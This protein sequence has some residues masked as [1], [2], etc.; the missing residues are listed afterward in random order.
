VSTTYVDGTTPLDAVHMNALQQK[1][2]KSQANG[3]AALD[4]TGKVPAAQLPGAG[5]L[6]SPV[7]NGQWVKGVGGAAVWAPIGATDLPVVPCARVFHNAAQATVSG[8]DTPLA[9]NSELFDT[10]TIHDPAT[11]NTRLTCKTAGVYQIS[12]SAEWAANPTNGYLKIN[13]N[14]AMPIAWNHMV[15]GDY[16]RMAVSTLY[17]LAVNDYVELVAAQ[18]SGGAINVNSAAHYSPEF[19]MV[20]ASA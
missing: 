2:E 3:Y 18:S 20:R 6:P 13:L 19:M 4:G 8:V 14:G 16:R 11:N 1:A 15:T 5:T 7:V 9:F 10:D 17:Q 12:G